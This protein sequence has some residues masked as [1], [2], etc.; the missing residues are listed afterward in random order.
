MTSL[1]INTVKPDIGIA[2]TALTADWEQLT[3]ERL[4]IINTYVV[5]V[6]L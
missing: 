1:E 4:T 6:A 2:V 3:V 5:Y